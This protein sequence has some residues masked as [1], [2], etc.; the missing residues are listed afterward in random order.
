MIAVVIGMEL[1][2]PQYR[3][4]ASVITGA[5]FALGQVLFP[6]F[7]LLRSS[8]YSG[9]RSM[10]RDGLPLAAHRHLFARNSFLVVLVVSH[11]PTSITRLNRLVP[12]SSRW[13]VS[14]KRFEEADKILQ[15]AARING[16]T[17]P[18][19]WWDQLEFDAD[20]TTATG[21]AKKYGFTDLFKTPELRKRT[22]VAFYLW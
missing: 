17:L 12:E 11:I 2:G 18:A 19:K 13:L 20:S 14:Q 15:K 22:L 5:F 6:L 16:V 7:Q 10:V 9:V 4:L 8:D 1:V 3:K 21:E